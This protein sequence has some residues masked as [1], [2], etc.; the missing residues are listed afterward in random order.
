MRLTVE[1]DGGL[2]FVLYRTQALPRAMACGLGLE[3]SCLAQGVLCVLL[4]QTGLGCL[5]VF[6]CRSEELVRQE[7]LDLCERHAHLVGERSRTAHHY[8]PI[9]RRDFH[10]ERQGSVN[11]GSLERVHDLSL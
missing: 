11:R 6:G 4:V 1:F 7:L 9:G 3:R 8:L 10:R 2:F 5:H